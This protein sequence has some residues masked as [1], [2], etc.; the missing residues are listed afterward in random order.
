MCLQEVHGTS[1]ELQ[2]ACTSFGSMEWYGYFCCSSAAGGCVILLFRTFLGICGCDNVVH[3]DVSLGRLH[4]VWIDSGTT[5]I[6]IVNV[7]TAPN[8]PGPTYRGI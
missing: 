1:A 4:Y 6:Q 5:K 8:K 2:R 7:H 3:V